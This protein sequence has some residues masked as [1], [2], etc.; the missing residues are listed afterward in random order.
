MKQKYRYIGFFVDREELLHVAER[1]SPDR[2]FKTIS[3]PHVTVKH[4]P[5]T[6]DTSLFGEQAEITITGYGNDG[7]NEGFEIEISTKNPMLQE[8]LDKIE[9]PHITLS[10]AEGAKAV[11]TRYIKF[12]P[13][14][15]VK[16]IGI[17]GGYVS[18]ERVD[19]NPNK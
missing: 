9:V 11:N 4:L 14:T 17:F 19:T 10:I 8:K 15:P 13:I 6:V 7:N 2:L 1:L 16:I 5:E 18:D 12:S 3:R